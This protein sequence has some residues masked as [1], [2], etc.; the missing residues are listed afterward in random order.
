M[1]NGLRR[2]NV[3]L[4]I[5]VFFILTSKCGNTVDP[6]S[7]GD[8]DRVDELVVD[9]RV[10]HQVFENRALDYIMISDERTNDSVKRPS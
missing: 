10:T 1:E 4:C 9:G 6:R 5:F 3:Q 8:Q 2:D 7:R